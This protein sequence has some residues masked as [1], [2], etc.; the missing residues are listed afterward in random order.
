M[1]TCT[2][3]PDGD[4]KLTLSNEGRRNISEALEQNQG[5]WTIM[6]DLFE[7]YSCNGSFTHFDA[8]EANPFVGLTSAPCIAEAMDYP[9]NGENEVVGR[10]WWLSDYAIRDDLEELRTLGRTVYHLAGDYENG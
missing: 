3:L 1:L 5:Y 7:G 9:D 8:G 6:A 2:I 10:L 4:L